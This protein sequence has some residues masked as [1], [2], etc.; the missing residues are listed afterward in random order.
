MKPIKNFIF[1]AASL[2]LVGCSEN[3]WNDHLDGFD[4][5][6]VGAGTVTVDYTLTPADYKLIAS[7]SDNLAIAAELGQEEALAAI[8]A[9][10]CFATD[11]DAQR[12]IPALLAS[13]S[14]GLPYFTYNNGS[15]VNIEYALTDALPENVK[16]INAGTLSYKLSEQD[17]QNVWGSTTDFVES[18]TPSH[19]PASV[20]P[21]L[22]SSGLQAN[23]GQYAVALY[24]YSDAEPDFATPNPPEAFEPTSIAG[25]AAVGEE[26]S[27]KGYVAAIDSRGFIV[28]DNSGAI[29]CYQSSGFDQAS[30]ELGNEITVSGTVS[31]YN[32]GIQIPITTDSYQVHGKG[33]YAYPTP[34][35]VT[36]PDMDVA[37]TA[38]DDFHPQYVS[39]TGTLTIS[40]NYYNVTVDGAATAVGSLYMVPDYLKPQLENG[41][42]Y[43]FNGYF[44]AI[45]G[46]KYYNIV[47]VSAGAPV[48]KVRRAPSAALQMAAL[49][50]YDGNAWKASSGEVLIQ[51][52]AYKEIM[53]LSY[54]N[55]SGTQPDEYIPVYLKQT[56]PFAQ[57]GTAKTVVYLYHTSDGDS[58]QAREYEKVDGEWVR[59]MGRG[60]SKFTR[61]DYVWSFNPSV[62]VTLPYARNTEPAYSYYMA[63]VEW[64][65]ENIVKPEN[66]GATLTTATP[67]IDYRGNAEFYSGA[68]AFYGNVDVRA[69]TAT[70]HC[71]EGFYDGL[72]DDEISALV[73]KRFCL[74][75]MRGALKKMHPDIKPVEGMEVT[76]TIHFTAF[77]PVS[78]ETLVYTVTGPAEFTYKSCTWF[79]KNEDAG[80]E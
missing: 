14:S 4:V 51:P 40:G 37:I 27:I 38:T 8:G 11:E 58:Y 16:A 78:E 49:Y 57:D 35:V 54:A 7:N 47:V 60:V 17:Y 19:A 77:S 75:T 13:A 72:T 41:K 76:V 65:L 66:P 63:C 3:S 55:F 45:S 79:K 10:A 53:G 52:Y 68:S 24:N 28:A 18:L 31:S 70:A 30:V 33:S 15:S 42:T 12:Y 5:P 22:L 73:K 69:G 80:W 6:E 32:K 61:K 21:G 2:A 34:K 44:M 23:E 64:V 62:E 26:V 56:F 48:A 20:L 71:P 59:Q 9:N 43:T 50:R 36:G 67:L 1:I 25:K 29:L 39:L 74:E 46:G